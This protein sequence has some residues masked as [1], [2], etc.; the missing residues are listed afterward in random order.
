MVQQGEHRVGRVING[1]ETKVFRPSDHK[2]RDLV[3]GKNSKDSDIV[4]AFCESGL[5]RES[6]GLLSQLTDCHKSAGIVAKSDFS[7]I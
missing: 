5:V 1:V 2:Q 3:Y 7:R 6:V 4:A